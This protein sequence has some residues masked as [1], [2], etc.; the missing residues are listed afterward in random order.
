[1]Q[2]RA[3]RKWTHDAASDLTAGAAAASFAPDDNASLVLDNCAVN[4]SV[5]ESFEP[6]VVSGR[7]EFTRR[8]GNGQF[9]FSSGVDRL[10]EY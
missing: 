3:L 9:E 8:K 7:W 1:M 6:I 5:S 2:S 10:W 4:L